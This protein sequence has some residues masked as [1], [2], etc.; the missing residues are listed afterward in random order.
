MAKTNESQIK[1]SIMAASNISRIRDERNNLINTQSVPKHSPIIKNQSI[2]NRLL[3]SYF[4]KNGLD[5]DK[6]DKILLQ[7]Q[8]EREL[9][10]EKLKA[11]S[12]TESAKMKNMQYKTIEN[13]RK[14][15]ETL[16][17]NVT[18]PYPYYVTLDKPFLIWPTSGLFF[19]DS[20][21]EPWNSWGKV[22]LDSS[23][24][25]SDNPNLFWEELGFY[26]LWENPVDKWAVINVDGYLIQNGFCS[27]QSDGGYFAGDRRSSVNIYSNLRLLEWWNQP[28]TQPMM[29]SDQSQLI[30]SISCYSGDMFDFDGGFNGDYIFRG[31][32]SRYN[33]FLIPPNGVT[34]FEIISLISY[35]NG[36][37][38]GSAHVDFASNDFKVTCPFVL[39]A[40]LT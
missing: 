19:D 37:N 25:S 10:L 22:K 33:L 34:V 36:I 28:P 6:F 32:D 12:L 17:N 3:T 15:I 26:F 38:G 31:S 5:F 13:R 18:A 2:S 30:F 24:S 40:I 11:D 7:N 29:Q 4:S 39:L 27:V 14:T 35:S 1:N 9:I 20:H 21:Y 16:T 8:K 23:K